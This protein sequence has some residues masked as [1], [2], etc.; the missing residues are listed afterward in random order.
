MKIRTY[1]L[2]LIYAVIVVSIVP[3][4]LVALPLGIREP[5]F[6]YA[7]GVMWFSQWFLGLRLEVGGREL[8]DRTKACV[9]MANHAS[10]IDGPL[11][12]TVI[13]QRVRVMLK[14]SIFRLPVLGFGMKYVGFIPV[15]RKHAQRGKEAIEN[16]ARLMRERGYSFLIFPEGTRTLDGRMGPFRRGGFFL[17]LASGAPIVPVAIRG[18]FQIMPKGSPF[19]KKGRIHVA[20]RPPISV[21]GAGEQELPGLMERVRSSIQAGLKEESL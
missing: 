7:R 20:F 2:V 18:T 8:V 11:L 1:F 15:D 6:E 10:F 19:P 13:P 16:A 17:A 4:L 12:F 14:K 21:Q 5:L 3:L 9:F